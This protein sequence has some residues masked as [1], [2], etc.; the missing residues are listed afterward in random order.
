MMTKEWEAK[1]AKELEDNVKNMLKVSTTFEANK[2]KGM[3]APRLV[4]D[5]VIKLERQAMKRKIAYI[6]FFMHRSKE[7]NKKRAPP[8]KK[9]EERQEAQEGGS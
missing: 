3:E 9:A 4:I 2:L 7:K 1:L 5:D 6:E 8:K